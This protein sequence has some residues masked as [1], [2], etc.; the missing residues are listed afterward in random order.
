MEFLVEG[1]KMLTWQQLVMYGIGVLLIWLAIKKEYEPALLLPMGFGAILVNLPASGVLNQILPG[2]GEAQGIIQWLFEI[3]IEASEAMPVLLF[4]GIGAMIDFGPLLSNPKM[5]LFGAGAQFGIFAAILLA[6]VLGFDLNDA[7]SI[8]IIGAADGPTSILVSQ[9]LNSNYIGAIAVAAYSYMALVPVIQPFAIRLV[10]TKKERM[11]RMDYNPASV[12]KTARIVFPIAVTAVVGLVAPSSVALVG[13]LMFGNLIRECGVLT[14]MSETAQTTL[15][16][17]ITLLLGITISFSM[18]ADKFVTID[19]LM[20]ML[21]G[22]F[23]FVADTI[24]G[25]LLAKFINLFSK[26]KINPMVG[27][28]GISAF[29]MSS[30]VV[31]KMAMQED[32]GNV[33]LMHAAGANVSGQIASVIAG[34]LVINL[35]TSFLG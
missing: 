19:T 5:F 16:N 9:I 33:I 14:T 29:P 4:I 1:L 34:G 2:V 26:K 11:I 18:Q 20:I 32:P 17:L 8:G 10:T 22:V 28:A 23:A 6:V 21:I 27:A 25:V 35:V 3:G 30:R 13:F 24:G 31:Q 7:A 15:A 12:S